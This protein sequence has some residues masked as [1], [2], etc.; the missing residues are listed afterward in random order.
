MSNLK[1]LLNSL[2]IEADYISLRSV[3]NKNVNISVRDEIL[4]GV[5]SSEDH[6]LMVEVMIDGQIAYGATNSFEP[7]EVLRCA[8][9]A[10]QSAL[11]AKRFGL[12]P[13]SEHVRPK[14]VGEY[15]SPASHGIEHFKPAEL[16]ELL[17]SLS[18]AMKIHEHVI[19]RSASFSLTETESHMVATNGSDVFQKIIRSSIS[20]GATA[21][22]SVMTKALNPVWR[23]LIH[24]N[25]SWPQKEL[26]MKRWPYWKPLNAQ[27]KHWI[28]Y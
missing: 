21:A 20:L 4:E 11:M 8:L 24:I 6:G 9:K 10:K 12:F 23:D 25:Y 13:F 7:S 14:V 1:N 27:V 16:S 3:Y 18:S 2:K 22:L 19:S 5:S 15:Q 26:P 17:M 28:Y